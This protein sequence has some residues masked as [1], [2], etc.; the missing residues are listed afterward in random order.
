MFDPFVLHIHLLFITSNMSYIEIHN[1]NIHKVT[2][3][4]L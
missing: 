3:H 1:M 2:L 4:N